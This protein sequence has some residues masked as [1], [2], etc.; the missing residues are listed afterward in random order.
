MRK[1]YIYHHKDNENDFFTWMCNKNDS[2]SMADFFDTANKPGYWIY[3]EAK[4]APSWVL[5]RL[6]LETLKAVAQT[7]KKGNDDASF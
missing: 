2:W 3:W 6:C 7:I 5:N 4:D 1:F